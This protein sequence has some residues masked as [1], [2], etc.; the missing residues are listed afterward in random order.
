MIRSMT[1]FGKAEYNDAGIILSAEVHSINSRYLDLKL[2][3]PNALNQY[4]P[5]IRKQIQSAFSRGRVTVTIY[6]DEPAGRLNNLRVNFELA[7][8]YFQLSKEMSERYGIPDG[9]DTRSIMSLP[10]VVSSAEEKGS[11]DRVWDLCRDILQKAIDAN[12]V[13]RETEGR[14]IGADVGARLGKVRNSMEEIRRRATELA[15]QNA[16]RLREKIGKL[17]DVDKIDEQRLAME[18]AL[19]ADRIDITEECVRHASH[20]DEFEKELKSRMG[21]GKKLSFLLQEMH[22]EANTIASK[23]N[24]A[25]ISQL[26]VLIKEEQEKMREQV[27]NME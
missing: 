7:E 3:F 27:E 12:T 16:V 15:V 8:R 20:C 13:S 22:R 14:N 17:I 11:T 18:A 1:G 19:Y 23:A 5:D 25:G 4:E 10:D 2:K 6:L 26:I 24:D 9:L 21:S